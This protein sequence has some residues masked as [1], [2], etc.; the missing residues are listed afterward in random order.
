METRRC[1]GCGRAFHPRPQVPTQRF[2]ALA[3]CQRERRRRWQAAKRQHDPD[4]RDN[5]GVAQRRWLARHPHY[6]RDY[7][8]RHPDS[9][10]RNREAQRRRNA[11]R[12][13]T[14]PIAKIAKSDA[15]TPETPLPVGIYRLLPV[16]GPGI[17]KMDA[18]TV[19]IAV[20]SGTY[21]TGG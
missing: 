15:S 20:L 5:Q 8:A 4:Y 12:R 6:W 11:A 18:W 9:V 19:K 21:G 14:G 16:A 17:A 1:A 3:R 2:C 13:R 7:R 10:T